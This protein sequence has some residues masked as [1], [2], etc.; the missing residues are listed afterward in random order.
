MVTNIFIVI[1][2]VI[3]II[4]VSLQ[5][6]YI[7][8]VLFIKQHQFVPL[9][10]TG[11]LKDFIKINIFFEYLS[12]YPENINQLR[13]LITIFLDYYKNVRR[14]KIINFLTP[15]EAVLKFLK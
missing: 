6:Y 12:R 9:N 4:K 11:K 3:N 2:R 5:N 13:K 7:K 1:I 14:H 8:N 10:Q 15:S